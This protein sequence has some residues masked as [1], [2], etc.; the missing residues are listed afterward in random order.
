[1]SHVKGS[2]SVRQHHQRRGKRLGVKKFGGQEIKVGQ[3]ILRQ[4]GAKYK[5]GKNVGM[6]RD[7]TIFAMKDGKV[8]FGK[9]W[10]RTLVSV[11]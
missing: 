10:G 2:G 5:T 7:Y 4:K 6:G 1:M 9:K 3:I 11:E 8:A